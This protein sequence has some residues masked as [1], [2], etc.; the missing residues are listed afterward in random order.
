M[1]SDNID[2]DSLILPDNT[3]FFSFNLVELI[4]SPEVFCLD[5]F[6]TRPLKQHYHL[7]KLSVT[8]LVLSALLRSIDF[9]NV[10]RFCFHQFTS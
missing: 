5:S 8:V 1:L 3:I 7:I 4:F 2:Q 6:S 9:I 10:V